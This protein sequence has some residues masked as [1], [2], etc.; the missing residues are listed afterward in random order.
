MAVG[1]GAGQL[2]GDLGAE[3]RRGDHAEVMLDRGQV[4]AG[5]VVQ[6][7]PRRVGQ[8]RL[9]V[10]RVVSA[11]GG[12]ADQ[13]LVAAAVGDLHQAQPV[14]RGD[15][16]HGL[17]IDRDRA[18]ARA[19]LRGDLLRGNGQPFGRVLRPIARRAKAR[20]RRRRRQWRMR[21]DAIPESWRAALAPVLA[22]PR[23]ASRSAASSA[24]EEAAGKAIYPPRGQRLRALELTPLDAGQG[25]DPRP[26]PL[27]RRRARPTAWRSRC[28]TGVRVPPS[29]ANIY[30][31]LASDLGIAAARRTATS[32][33]GRGRACCCSTTAL[34]VEAGRAGSH[35]RQGLGGDHRRRGRRGRRARGAERVH[36]VG[37]PRPGQGG[38]RAGARPTAATW[39]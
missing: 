5:E 10:G 35:Q 3:H 25:R 13:M 39:C 33:A 29:L 17:G 32:S 37:Q 26:G 6:L 20:L 8:H 21:S 30:K 28:P 19:R 36:A 34:T 14:A 1:V 4:E 38:A 9:E 24:R 11:A 22:T 12:E 16:A 31:E 27:P 7:E 23:G 2:A 18:R 15:Q